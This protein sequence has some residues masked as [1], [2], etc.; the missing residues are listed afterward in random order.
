MN[1]V[2]DP[3]ENLIRHIE[4]IYQR[5][6]KESGKYSRVPSV[7]AFLFPNQLHGD[8]DKNNAGYSRQ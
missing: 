7:E 1:L 6:Q 5:Y 3:K 4:L 2:Q 8:A